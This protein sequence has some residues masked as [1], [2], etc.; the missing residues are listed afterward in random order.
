VDVASAELGAF[1]IELNLQATTNAHETPIHFEC[2]LGTTTTQTAKVLNYGKTKADFLVKV[3]EGMSDFQLLSDRTTYSL[4]LGT[5]VNPSEQTIEIQFD[6]RQL[7]E[8]G[9]RVLATSP[10]AGEFLFVFVGICLRPKPKGPYIITP[11]GDWIPPLEFKNPFLRPSAFNLI[12]S[13]PLFQ[14]KEMTDV[15]KAKKTINLPITFCPN[16]VKSDLIRTATVSG[17]VTV[18][19]KFDGPVAEEENVEWIYYLKAESSCQP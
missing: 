12:S 17:K 18:T 2:V 6:P 4:P 19:P 10:S 9:G 1:F 7:G 13:N 5:M 16:N 8:F 15:L 14:V 11:T 3:T